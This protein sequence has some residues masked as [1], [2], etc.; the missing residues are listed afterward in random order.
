MHSRSKTTFFSLVAALLAVVLLQPAAAGPIDIPKKLSWVAEAEDPPAVMRAIGANPQKLPVEFVERLKHVLDDGS[1]Q[2]MVAL[3]RRDTEVERF[4]RANTRWV[5]WYGDGPRFLGRVT[6][7]QFQVLLESDFVDFVEPDYIVTNFMAESTV[8]VRAR[9]TGDGSGVW[10]FDPAGGPKGA[11]HSDIPDVSVDAATGKGVVVAITD[12]GIDKTFRDFG[13]WDCTPG[14]YQPC[15][16]R[17]VRA[18]T[19]EHLITGVSDPA[20]FLPTTEA[21]SGHGSHVAGTIAGNGYYT[22]DGDRD[23][24]YGG[25]QYVFGMAPQASLIS[26]KNGDSQSAGLST[27]ALQWQL[28]H[29]QELGIKVSSNSWGCLGGCTLNPNSV[30]YQIFRELY[31]AGVV[32]V[33]AAGNDDGGPDGAAL[34]GYSQSP[35]VVGVAAY[36]DANDTLA[37]F[38]SRG[39]STAPLPDPATWTPESEPPVGHRRPDVAA[40]GVNIWSAGTLTGGTSSITPRVAT[41][42]V[43]G[44]QNVCCTV[45][46]RSMS[47]TSMAAPHVAGAAALLR[48]VCSSSP[49]IDVMRALF[50]AADEAKVKVGSR[51]AQPYEVGYGAINVRAAVDW[52][53]TQQSCGGTGGGD[54][55]PTESP[56]ESPS[57]IPTECP[58]SEPATS[59]RYYFHSPS[60]LGNIDGLQSL[61]TFDTS[62]PTSEAASEYFDVPFLGNGGLQGPYDPSWKGQITGTIGQLD[63]DF[64]TFADVGGVL[65]TAVFDIYLRTRETGD[66]ATTNQDYFVGRISHSVEAAPQNVKASFTTLSDGTTLLSSL[67]LSGLD[68]NVTIRPVPVNGAGASILYDSTD[69]Q[70]GFSIEG[71]SQNG[72]GDCESPS[73]TPTVQS[74]SLNFADDSATAGQY[75]D[76]VAVAATLTD[77]DGAPIADSEVVFEL[78][79]GGG[80]QTWSAVTGADGVADSTTSLDADPGS[81]TLTARYAG[82]AE[83]YEGSADVTGFAIEK[84]DSLSTLAVTGKGSKRSLSATLADADSGSGLAGET[85]EFFADGR[86]IGT[87]TTNDDGL[88][89]MEIPPKYRNGHTAFEAVFAG[90]DYYLR[91]SD[92]R[93]T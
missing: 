35:F 59:T 12:S 76:E 14:P 56:S 51:T 16:S 60:G 52:L 30:I 4:V 67:P 22:R 31:A 86:S 83:T 20:P 7:D 62:A 6:P 55:T 88:A 34:S 40:P 38:S 87:A 44:G 8:D 89:T 50:V 78:E 72:S 75:S 82:E 24:R 93:Q 69:Y 23:A 28:E 9:G 54:P 74:T 77:E 41:N 48:S 58:S 65:G 79:G 39:S 33:F 37:S 49:P 53:R 32:T 3:N 18:V 64:W 91:S 27:D 84:D 17:I 42:D 1:L 19:T 15:Q 13:G 25:D 11:L 45:P 46:Y 47:G 68:I 85:F 61:T 73:P 92:R 29:A 66:P 90:N 10:S 80:A 81:Y 5:H 26:V 63:V 21:A 43:T 36:D 70:S 71:G 57:A 2:V